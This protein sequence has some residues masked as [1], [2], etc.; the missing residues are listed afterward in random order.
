MKV[1]VVDAGC[2]IGKTT[3][4]INKMNEDTSGQKYLFVTPFLSEV[5]RI[6]KACPNKN[7]VSQTPNDKRGTKIEHLTSLI[8]EGKNV[9]TT[10]ALFKKIDEKAIYNE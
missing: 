8:R 7:F 6:K 5:E 1:N 9:V 4:L 3:A 2:G 10:H